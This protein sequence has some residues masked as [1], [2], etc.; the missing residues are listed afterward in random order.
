MGAFDLT[1]P[2]GKGPDLLAPETEKLAI[3]KEK[4]ATC[5]LLVRLVLHC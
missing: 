5:G 4:P 3:L 2:V 1:I